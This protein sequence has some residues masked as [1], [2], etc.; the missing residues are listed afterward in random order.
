MSDPTTDP[1]VTVTDVTKEVTCGD[2]RITIFIGA[3][4]CVR[5]SP[6]QVVF[7][8]IP[9]LIAALHTAHDIATQCSPH[10]EVS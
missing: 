7:D 9:N 3:H 6:N 2:I 5:I 1:N 10:Q 8:E 4:G